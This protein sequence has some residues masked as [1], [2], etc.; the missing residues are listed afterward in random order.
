MVC[1]LGL[2]DVGGVIHTAINIQ[3]KGASLVN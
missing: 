2:E 1:D 3:L